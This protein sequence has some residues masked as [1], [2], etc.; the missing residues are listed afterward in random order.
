MSSVLEQLLLKYPKK[1][2][3]FDKLSINPNI[4]IEFMS[5]HL[6]YTWNWMIVGGRPDVTQSLININFTRF[7]TWSGSSLS[8]E[9]IEDHMNV[10]FRCRPATCPIKRT[11]T[12]EA[13]TEN[14]VFCIWDSI[15]EN[16][17]LTI[18]FIRKYQ[19]LYWWDWREISRNRGIGMDDI[20]SNLDLPWEWTH[21]AHNPNVSIDFI[22]KH[23]KKE[24]V[25]WSHMSKDPKVTMVDIERTKKEIPWCFKNV[26]QNPNL[27]MR[28]VCSQMYYG[29]HFDSISENVGITIDDLKSY[30]THPWN[31][32]RI[33]SNPGITIDDI[34]ATPEFPWQMDGISRNPN[35][36]MEFI[37]RNVDKIFWEGLSGNWF[38]WHDRKRVSAEFAD[39]LKNTA[40]MMSEV[41]RYKPGGVGYYEAK[42]HFET[43]KN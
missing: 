30:P 20:E 7:I 21:V 8:L 19:E 9:F 32:A 35:I 37:D 29:W 17:N 18:P 28:Y 5:E 23:D 15:S 27:T 36:T 24:Y 40:E 39:E 25:N 2:W 33:S 10:S 16:P 26:S 4:S 6:E 41:I 14:L 43:C 38:H 42:E 13:L 12:N 22:I 31:F 11:A 3:D 34:E 1:D